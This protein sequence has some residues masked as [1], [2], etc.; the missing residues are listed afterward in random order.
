LGQMISIHL[1]FKKETIRLFCRV[2]V[3]F[4]VSISGI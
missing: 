3:P 1:A 2:T 4:F